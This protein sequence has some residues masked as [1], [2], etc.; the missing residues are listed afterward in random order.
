[1]VI[2]L[3]YRSRGCL[4]YGM[5]KSVGLKQAY[6]IQDLA[7]NALMAM[8]DQLNKGGKWTVTREDA[9]ALAALVKAHDT[10]QDRIRIHRGKALP[11]SLRPEKPA[12][13]R[14]PALPLNI[15]HVDEPEQPTEEPT[16]QA[17]Q[18]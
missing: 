18:G 7:Y 14:K 13:R 5:G 1:M 4:S 16:P 17:S 10:A 11:G 6:D 3:A 12:S 2:D 15:L 9:Q 8:K